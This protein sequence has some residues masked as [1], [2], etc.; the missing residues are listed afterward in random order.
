MT[1]TIRSYSELSRIED[2]LERYRYLALRGVVGNS[3]FGYERWMNQQFYTSIQWR[4]VRY[5]V[6]ARDNGCDL[7]VRDH[8][9]HGR[10]YIHHM[11]PLTVE[12]LKQGSED[13]IDPEFLITTRHETHNAIHYGDEKLLPHPM[14]V[15]R[16]GDTKLW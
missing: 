2:F 4:Q 1:M 11:N 3:T 5:H 8:E 10:L 13:I 15:R 9:I 12:D 16:A 6:I 7:G 14:V